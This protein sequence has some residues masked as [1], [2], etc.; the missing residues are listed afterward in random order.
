MSMKDVT[1]RRKR[2]SQKNK[3]EVKYLF[4]PDTYAKDV[5][6]RMKNQQPLP[7]AL[8]K[9]LIERRHRI[10]GEKGI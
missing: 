4:R 1:L 2:K 10:R 9:E 3:G 7:Q 5:S 6:D 8:A